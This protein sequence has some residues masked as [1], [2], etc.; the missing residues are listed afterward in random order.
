M[1]VI[2]R[3][4]VHA[5]LIT[6]PGDGESSVVILQYNIE[7]RWE[8]LHTAKNEKLGVCAALT[9]D[10]DIFERETRK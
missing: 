4:R 8:V 5:V 7:C 1:A 9:V 6:S 3:K 2:F 10:R